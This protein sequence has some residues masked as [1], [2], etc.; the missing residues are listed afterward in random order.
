MA[1]DFA[2]LDAVKMLFWSAVTNGVLAPPLIVLLVLLT[3]DREGHGRA[4]QFAAPPLARLDHRRGDDGRGSRDVRRRLTPLVP[5]R[6]VVRIDS[7]PHVASLYP[8]HRR[9]GGLHPFRLPARTRA[10]PPPARGYRQSPAGVACRSRRS[11]DS[12]CTCWRGWWARDAR[13]KSA[14]SWAI[15][16]PGSRWRCPPD[17]KI[18]AC[19]VS[20]EYTARARR[21]WSRGRRPG[22]DRPAPPAR[23][24]NARRAARRG[25]GRRLRLRLHRRRQIELLELLR[26]RAAAGPHRRPD[27]RSTTCLWH[28]DVIDAARPHARHRSHSRVQS[29]DPRRRPRRPEPRDHRRRADA[30]VQALTENPLPLLRARR[31]R[32]GAIARRVS[33]TRRRRARVPRR[34]RDAPRRGARREGARGANGGYR[35]RPVLPRVDAVAL[36]ARAMGGRAGERAQSR[37]RSDR[38]LALRR[39]RAAQSPH[40]AV[41]GSASSAS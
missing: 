34:R 8:D 13:S 5:S 23:A 31:P 28:G 29:Q 26:A 6:R 40:A 37:G 21:T 41:H 18:I 33:R 1:L 35:G 10:A 36:A 17:G 38:L 30:G 22:Q 32:T 14:C 9:D 20:E 24:G 12:S 16:L 4:R 15:A 39:L 19:D 11:R 3:S 25:P 7:S 2:G 27:R